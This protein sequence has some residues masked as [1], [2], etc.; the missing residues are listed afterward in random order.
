MVIRSGA[1]YFCRLKKYQFGHSMMWHGAMVSSKRIH[2]QLWCGTLPSYHLPNH[3][4][5]ELEV[6]KLLS[7]SI[8]SSIHMLILTSLGLETN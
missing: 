4:E 6:G 8:S 1:E 2:T 3:E 5:A 7:Q